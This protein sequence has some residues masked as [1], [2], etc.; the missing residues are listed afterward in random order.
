MNKVALSIAIAAL[1]P[2][3]GCK[4]PPPPAVEGVSIACS[5]PQQDRCWEYSQ[6]TAEQRAAI[7]VE[8]SSG[9]AKLST[10]AACPTAGFIGKCT[11]AAAGKGPEIRRWYKADDAAYQ[12]DFCVNTAKGVWTKTF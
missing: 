11:I 5:S 2:C 9:S 10:P 3:G 12:E 6:P 7:T 1:I 8:C 4:K